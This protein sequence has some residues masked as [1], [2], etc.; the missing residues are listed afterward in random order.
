MYI[1]GGSYLSKSSRHSNSPFFVLKNTNT[2]VILHMSV[3]VRE[4]QKF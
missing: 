4:G 3:S 1:T 2:V